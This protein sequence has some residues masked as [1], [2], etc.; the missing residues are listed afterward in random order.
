MVLNEEYRDMTSRH[1]WP[2]TSGCALTAGG[3]S[4]PDDC[5][6]DFFMAVRGGVAPFRFAVFD[7]TGSALRIVVCD[8]ED[9]EVA[10]LSG[11]PDNLEIP[12]TDPEGRVCGAAV[13]SPE[14]M[15]EALAFFKGLKVTSQDDFVLQPSCVF[16]TPAL[17]V[18]AL[19]AAGTTITGAAELSTSG[20]LSWGLD[21]S[22][23]AVS[24]NVY[25]DFPDSGVPVVTVNGRE[26]EHLWL[27][28]D[29]A[30]AVRVRTEPSQITI[31]KSKDFGVGSE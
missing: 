2:F 5:F 3:W 28:S 16:I 8:A 29:A 30:S 1:R 17:G 24:L 12:V 19:T 4:A 6:L 7:G 18:T 11:Q 21:T 26:M 14:R 10:E 22:T 31:G 23:G 27:V 25:G 13:C 9:T 15:T 20:P